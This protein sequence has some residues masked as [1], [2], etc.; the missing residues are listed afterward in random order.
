MLK[1]EVAHGLLSQR[2]VTKLREQVAGLT[3]QLASTGPATGRKTP[4]ARAKKPVSK[5]KSPAGGPSADN[6]SSN[7][8][9]E[10]SKLKVGGA[11][12]S[13]PSTQYTPR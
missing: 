6:A 5:R 2:Q 13:A 12:H 7:L 9:A 1:Q 4:K 3:A 10:V 11:T 8:A